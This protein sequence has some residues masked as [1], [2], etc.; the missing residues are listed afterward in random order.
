MSKAIRIFE[1]D[2]EPS[3]ESINTWK[4]RWF[5][6][7][8]KGINDWGRDS[9]RI[10]RISLYKPFKTRMMVQGWCGR[11]RVN[12]NNIFCSKKTKMRPSNNRWKPSGRVREEQ[13]SVLSRKWWMWM[14]LIRRYIKK[15]T[16]TTNIIP[17]DIGW[18][19]MSKNMPRWN[20]WLNKRKMYGEQTKI[21]S[22]VMTEQERIL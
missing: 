3:I 10:G 2:T 11:N 15:G 13:W 4:I 21:I 1:R 18:N 16:W 22:I 8:M 14:K 5:G 17:K 6:S 19:K 20:H 7:W 12:I 9:G